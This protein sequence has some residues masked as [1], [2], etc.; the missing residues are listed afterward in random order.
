MDNVTELPRRDLIAEMTGPAAS[1]NAVIINGRYIPNLVMYDRG[2]EIEFVLDNRLAFG[3]SRDQAWNAAAFA[4]SAM[5]IGAGFA[6]P[7]HMHFTQRPFATEIKSMDR[8]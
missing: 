8:D 4:F 5:A 3:F 2:D 6:H 7:E 1:G